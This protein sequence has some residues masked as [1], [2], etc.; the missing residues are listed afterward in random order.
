MYKVNRPSIKVNPSTST[1]VQS[2]HETQATSSASPSLETIKHEH[3]VFKR[4]ANIVLRDVSKGFQ[5]FIA[6][7]AGREAPKLFGSNRSGR[8]FHA[9][10]SRLESFLALQKGAVG[11]S[12]NMEKT[13]YYQS[14]KN[15]AKGMGRVSESVDKLHTALDQA[16]SSKD[17]ASPVEL[18]AKLGELKGSI[19]T[20]LDHVNYPSARND[21]ERE[22]LLFSV[23]VFGDSLLEGIEAAAQKLEQSPDAASAAHGLRELVTPE[24]YQKALDKMNSPERLDFKAWAM[25]E[26]SSIKKDATQ[27]E[28]DVTAQ[29]AESKGID[30]TE[31][32]SIKQEETVEVLQKRCDKV[33][34][35]VDNVSSKSSEIQGHTHNTVTAEIEE[36]GLLVTH[37]ASKIDELSSEKATPA[38]AEALGNKE[39]TAS[40]AVRRTERK[41][42]YMYAPLRS[43][44]KIHRCNIPSPHKPDEVNPVFYRERQEEGLCVKHALN[45]F[46]GFEA[47]GIDDLVQGLIQTEDRY[48]GKKAYE[49]SPDLWL[50]A[51]PEYTRKNVEDMGYE[52]FDQVI[53]ESL[54]RTTGGIPLEDYV[55]T[56]NT[57]DVGLTVLASYQRFLRAPNLVLQEPSS[58]QEAKHALLKARAESD[59]I[60]VGINDHFVTYRENKAGDW[61]KIDSELIQQPREDPTYLASRMVG[62]GIV[63]HY[64]S[65]EPNLKTWPAGTIT[66]T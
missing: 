51:H 27:L 43:I 45:A 66:W 31:L 42:D 20:M 16:E 55:K 40:G 60:I 38:K 57:A 35:R 8:A 29:A 53:M 46:V 9:V 61:F 37:T 36:T 63:I 23:C 2:S 21:P 12:F 50:K 48:V 25:G 44:T 17:T 1:A 3:E 58:R 5:K 26:L 34:E 65:K 22:K 24:V 14:L 33:A 54:Q 52:I 15:V 64:A 39:Q 7:E 18:Q 10:S 30:S 47:F 6:E 32:D 11:R 41:K 49:E 13:P 59:R 56:K 62:D 28:A 19:E 4:D